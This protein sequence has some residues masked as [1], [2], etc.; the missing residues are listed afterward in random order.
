MKTF[1]L[2]VIVGIVLSASL[3][4]GGQFYD[5]SGHPNAPAGSVQQ[6]D[7]FR[8]RQQFLDLNAM[9]RNQEEQ[10]RRDKLNPCGR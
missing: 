8:S 10:M 4:L 2:G 5:S 6:F 3:G 1:A 9:R 7:Y